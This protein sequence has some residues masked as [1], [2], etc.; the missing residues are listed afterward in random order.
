MD[1]TFSDEEIE[2]CTLRSPREI[3]FQLKGL[4]KRNEPISVLFQEG[5]QSF[6]TVLLG[7]SEEAG[8]LYFDIGG[9]DETN[10]AFLKSEQST[11]VTFVDGIRYQFSA[12]KGRKLTHGGGPALAVPLP[13]SLL[14]LQRRQFFRLALPTTKPYICRICRGTAQEKAI[15][16]HDISVGGIGILSPQPIDFE[17]LEKL[18]NSWIDLHDSGVLAV[19]LEVR[20][21]ATR[22]NR[23]GKALWHVGCKFLSLSPLNDTLI[24]RFIARLQAE[25]KALQAG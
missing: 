21:I 2:N 18:E 12:R 1:T 24:Q 22:E 19:T 11:F 5:R 23:T 13:A 17:P 15:P 9:S 7:V 10:D 8:L 4:I 3:L 25:R 14:R 6:L 20:Y 16:V